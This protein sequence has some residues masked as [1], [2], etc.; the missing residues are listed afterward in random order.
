LASGG[1]DNLLHIWDRSRA[2]SNSVTQWLQ[3]LEDHTSAM[4]ALAQYPFQSNLLASGGGEGDRCIKFWNTHTGACFSSVNTGSLVF[5]LLWSK[6]E[7]ELLSSHGLPQNELIL[8]KYPS[9]VKMVEL[10]GHI[11]R[12]LFMAQVMYFLTNFP[13][14]SFWS[15]S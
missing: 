3:R 13:Y 12:V 6:N 5:A 11:S 9:M 2:T 10:K 14:H 1:S 8:W 15:C 4:K 7:K